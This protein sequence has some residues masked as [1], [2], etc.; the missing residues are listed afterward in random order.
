M[1]KLHEELD[2]LDLSPIEKEKFKSFSI[3]GDNGDKLPSKKI[4]K[5]SFSDSFVDGIIKKKRS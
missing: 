3:Q 2:S 4:A 5:L 1:A